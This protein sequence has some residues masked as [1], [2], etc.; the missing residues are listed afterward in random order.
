MALDL[1]A[2]MN[3][4]GSRL[5]T[6]AGLRVV[7]YPADGISPPAGVVSYPESVDYDET[8]R[9]GA[10]RATFPVHVLTGKVSD[11]AS[12]DR[13]GAFV[14][15]S[16]ASSVKTTLEA[17]PTLAGAVASLRVQRATFSTITVGAVDYV[18]ATF[19]VEV[20]A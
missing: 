16:G 3:A 14:A 20:I 1:N 19:D 11:R 17:D 18:A 8:Y 12:R 15:R 10:D 7:D 2:T 4:L 5:A 13:I 6:I 9:A